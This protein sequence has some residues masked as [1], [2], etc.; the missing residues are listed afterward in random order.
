MPATGELSTPEVVV[1]PGEEE[2]VG[3][4]VR[5]TGAAPESF[6]LLA[7][8][9]VQGWTIIDPPSVTL[10]PG[11]EGK[12]QIALRPPRRWS[13]PAG[14]S[15]LVIRIVAHD[16]VDDV[17]VAEGT[18]T[19]LGFDDRRLALAQSVQRGRRKAEFDVVLENL[20]NARASC[21]VQIVDPA[22][23]V[24]GRFDP[25]SMG[26][27]PGDSTSSRVVVK[28]RRARWARTARSL[29][30]EI[31]AVQEGHQSA[32]TA[33]TLLQTPIVAART[34]GRLSALVVA[35][36]LVAA[37]WFG[38]VDPAIDDA[39]RRAVTEAA[40]ASTTIVDP[41]ASAVVSTVAPAGVRPAAGGEGEAFDTRLAVTAALA[42]QTVQTY[43]VPPG[44]VLHV[45]DLLIQNP[46]ADSGR[47]TLLRNSTVL[48]EVALENFTDF[49]FNLVNPFVF[50]AG[51]SVN[52]Q[53]SC[54]QV[55]DPS[56]AACAV[57]MT[58]VGVLVDA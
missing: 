51:E 34:I 30:F 18:V 42:Q 8:G 43:A 13:V 6:S 41:N 3:L 25:P 33:G 12:V 7:T 21:R 48:Y 11:G 49:P 28:S 38:V 50:T 40:A 47:L 36:G 22:N 32:V 54:Q 5:N 52:V 17:A 58:L 35:A 46:N 24:V 2:L 56:G 20:G 14:A 15:P 10:P 55:G 26:V 57:A 37:G 19:V 1:V 16:S 4:T 29:P 27:D 39:A 23:R 44:K 31:A 53:L 9:L 45:S